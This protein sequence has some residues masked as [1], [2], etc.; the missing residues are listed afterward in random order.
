[1]IRPILILILACATFWLILA[2]PAFRLW[3]FRGLIESGVAASLC[4]LPSLLTIVWAW[5]ASSRP[6][7]HLWMALGSTGTRMGMVLGLAVLL[8]L[9]NPVFRGTSFWAWV[10]VFYL[11]TLAIDV[12]L[13]LRAK[14]KVLPSAD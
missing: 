12:V 13:L 7:D 8:A 9:L 10:L 5:L 2:Y 3:G 6:K 1:V 11:F 14:L 4:V